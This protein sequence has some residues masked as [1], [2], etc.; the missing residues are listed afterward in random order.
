M[1]Q[2]LAQ[3]A[4]YPWAFGL[5]L[6][7]PL[8]VVLLNE[9][10]ERVTRVYPR[11]G[12]AIATFRNLVLPLLTVRL[13]LQFIFELGPTTAPVVVAET[14]LWLAL[15]Y[16]A[17][18]LLTVFVQGLE[19]VEE[20]AGGTGGAT[21][22]SAK[23]PAWQLPRVWG[24]L[25]RIAT[26]VGVLFYMLS[27]IWGVPLSQVF[28]VLGV[29]SI[30]IG[31]ALQD[32]LSSL[33]SG[34]LLA[35]E[36][37]FEVGHWLRYGNYEGQVV[38]MNWRAVRLRTRERDV[39]IIPN[40]LLGKEVAVNFTIYDPL[41][42]ELVRVS[43][44]Y[45][46]PPNQIK[47]MLLE[48]ALATPGVRHEPAPHIR[49]VNYLYETAAIEYEVKLFTLDYFRIEF[50]RDEVLTRIYYAAQ[51][52]R[53]AAPYQTTIFY[54]RDQ[55]DLAQAD[56]RAEIRQRLQSV[57]FFAN[58]PEAAR[59]QLARGAFLYRFGVEEWIIQ[60]GA[61]FTGFYIILAGQVELTATVASQPRTII[62]L[63]QGEI[64]GEMVLLRNYPSPYTVTV[65]QDLQT[66]FIQRN[67]LIEVVES[68]L[69]LA[70]EMNRF[71]EQRQQLLA[72]V[73][74][75]D[76]VGAPGTNGKAQRVVAG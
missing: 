42:A 45:Q 67:T 20:Q 68:N 1:T 46:Y 33:V 9:L 26:V 13:I 28:A 30:V 65:R 66:L 40:A 17:L 63:N 21:S 3:S 70:T 57:P 37:P 69:R 56:D 29:G 54:Q 22:P 44:P 31:F 61:L 60:Q 6:G 41:H 16:A 34:L 49:I 2:F 25:L 71:I 72:R 38:E 36:K 55:A 5:F 58:L 10:I 4:F 50:I 8:L 35:F 43:F 11:L 51:R 62:T 39:V 32:T 74:E 64:F 75:L 27:N 12:R 23:A 15:V 59:E 48:T 52:Q 19:R 7:I 24:E 53:F 14:L 76:T 73:L 18:R 47:Q